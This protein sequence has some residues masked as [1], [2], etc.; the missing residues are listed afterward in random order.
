[1]NK[2]KSSEVDE[3]TNNLMTRTVDTSLFCILRIFACHERLNWMFCFLRRKNWAA[4]LKKPTIWLVCPAKTQINVGI[5][6]VWSESM[7]PGWRNNGILAT[8]SAHS[9]KSNQTAQSDLSIC[10]GC[11]SY[12]VVLS[13]SGSVMLY[14]M[15]STIKVLTYLALFAV[16]IFFTEI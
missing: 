12:Y 9:E 1:M 15:Y 11:T 10:S 2:G 14:A 16:S 4:A 6:P 3:I 5:Q 7:L 13:E 8:Y